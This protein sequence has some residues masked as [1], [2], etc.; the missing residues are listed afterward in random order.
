MDWTRVFFKHCLQAFQSI[1]IV[2]LHFTLL[3]RNLWIN[4]LIIFLIFIDWEKSTKI[5]SFFFKLLSKSSFYFFH[6]FF[7]LNFLLGFGWMFNSVLLQQRFYVCHCSKVTEVNML[8]LKFWLCVSIISFF[9]VK[10]LF[11]NNRF[12]HDLTE[13]SSKFHFDAHRFLMNLLVFFLSFVDFILPECKNLLNIINFIAKV[14]HTK[15]QIDKISDNIACLK[16]SC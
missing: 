4:I 13:I 3:E 1:G 16:C 15:D 5:T 7:L 6:D 10:G 14:K 12:G 9:F 11:A 8:P 2:V